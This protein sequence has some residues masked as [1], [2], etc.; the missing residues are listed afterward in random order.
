MRFIV[1][2]TCGSKTG[3][4]PPNGKGLDYAECCQCGRKI[5]KSQ[6]EY[7]RE[8]EQPETDIDLLLV[9]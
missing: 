1:A 3:T 7:I 5:D 8:P 9:E 4:T 6:G 2:C